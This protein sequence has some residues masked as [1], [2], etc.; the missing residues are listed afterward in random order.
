MKRARR[1]L[2]EQLWA[3]GAGADFAS[4]FQLDAAIKRRQYHCK[5]AENNTYEALLVGSGQEQAALLDELLIRESCF[6]RDQTPFTLLAETMAGRDSGVDILC[7]PC[8]GGEEP[9]SVVIALLEAGFCPESIRVE[10][11]DIS[12]Q[13]LIDAREGCYTENRLRLL[14][15][16]HKRRYF[17][18]M[19]DGRYRISED[20]RTCVRFTQGN[21]L[22]VQEHYGNRLFDSIFCRNLLIYLRSEC[23]RALLDS[24]MTLIKPD[25]LVFVGHAEAGLLLS[26]GHE[27]AGPMGCFAFHRHTGT[28]P[29]HSQP[30]PHANATAKPMSLRPST[31]IPLSNAVSL[32]SEHCS[33]ETTAAMPRQDTNNTKTL[34]LTTIIEL[35]DA[36]Q[37]TKAQTLLVDLLQHQPDLA[38]GHSLLGLIR[39]AQ[40]DSLGAIQ[41]LEKALY[42]DGSHHH[43]IEHLTLLYQ[44]TGDQAGLARMHR[45]R[46]KLNRD[47][48][49]Q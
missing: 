25:G 17:Q 29:K 32:P 40:G 14:S 48:Y 20:V 38:E 9:Y 27:I 31:P 13:G 43:S 3:A 1:L 36:G 4:D 12:T 10:A 47:H 6:F 24:L 30:K 2:R 45:K 8:A 34:T 21:A 37:Y 7:V 49:V 46:E 42:L 22:N 11:I 26:R 19:P 5:V 28:S 39:K 16:E 33:T 41:C 18:A 23:R 44:A 15:P 35:A